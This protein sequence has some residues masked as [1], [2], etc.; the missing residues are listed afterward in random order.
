MKA[1]QQ[2]KNKKKEEKKHV[3][4]PNKKTLFSSFFQIFSC[5][6]VNATGSYN[7]NLIYKA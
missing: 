1:Y 2:K 6:I 5:T 7:L 3:H 4:I